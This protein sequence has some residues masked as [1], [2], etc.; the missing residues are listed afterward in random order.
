MADKWIQ[1]A[2]LKEGAFTKKAKK[3]GMGVQEFAAHVRAHKGDYDSHTLRQANLARTFKKMASAEDGIV[4]KAT[5]SELLD[6]VYS[7]D[8]T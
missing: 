1:A 3:A 6:H 2:H 4:V 7:T 5:G 8:Y